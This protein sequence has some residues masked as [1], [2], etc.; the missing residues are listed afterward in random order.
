MPA[1]K[2]YTAQAKKTIHVN[3]HDRI[4]A[5]GRKVEERAKENIEIA[6]YQTPEPDNYRRTGLAKASIH[7]VDKSDHVLVGANE[8]SF[9]E[10][11]EKLSVDVQVGGVTFYLPYIEKGH[12]MRNGQFYP[13]RPFLA[14]ALDWARQK[15]GK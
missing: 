12:I 14:P 11:A 8:Q 1:S 15:W 3:A 7:T 5:I 2:I 10:D 4:L 9:K 13:A 6:V